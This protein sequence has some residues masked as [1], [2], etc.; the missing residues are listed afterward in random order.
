MFKDLLG[1]PGAEVFRGIGDF[2]WGSYEMRGSRGGCSSSW[3]PDQP[4]DQ[5]NWRFVAG[6]VPY[7]RGVA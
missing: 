2:K 3:G 6:S 5:A 7:F 4:I 1:T